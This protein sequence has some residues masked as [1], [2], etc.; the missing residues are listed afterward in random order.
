MRCLSCWCNPRLKKLP[1]SGL[2]AG[3]QRLAGI[4]KMF[5]KKV[6]RK[7]MELAETHAMEL[8]RVKGELDLETQSYTNY[9]LNVR[10][11]LRY[12]H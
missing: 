1:S 12:L 8:A 5:T 7:K 10:H 9:R 11:R 2:A 3:Y 6:E 4:H